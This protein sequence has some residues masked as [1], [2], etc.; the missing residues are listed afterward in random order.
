MNMKETK[1]ASSDRKPS[2]HALNSA[3]QKKKK[4]KKIADPVSLLKELHT[5][6]RL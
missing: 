6:G 4:K 5:N 1:T 3:K 2:K